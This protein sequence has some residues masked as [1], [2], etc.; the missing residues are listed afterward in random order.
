LFQSKKCSNFEKVRF[1]KSSE[2]KNIQNLK[3]QKQKRNS[4]ENEIRNR[5]KKKFVGPAQY[6]PKGVRQLVST[7]RVGVQ[8][9]PWRRPHA[10]P[11]RATAR[12]GRPNPLPLPLFFLALK[13]CRM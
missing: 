9:H 1:E 10:R 12:L 3:T 11:A 13:S 2:F 4:R 5:Q 8:H 6:L 7:D